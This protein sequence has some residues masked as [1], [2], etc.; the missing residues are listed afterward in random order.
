MNRK[1]TPEKE[2]KR[3]FEIVKIE[4]T[5]I[6]FSY[7]LALRSVHTRVDFVYGI[8]RTEIA[9]DAVVRHSFSLRD[10]LSCKHKIFLNS[11]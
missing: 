6:R 8:W 7:Y 9:V 5:R 1:K 11:E 3:N 10:L 2:L 4:E